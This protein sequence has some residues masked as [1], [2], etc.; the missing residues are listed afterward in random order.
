MLVPTLQMEELRRRIAVT[1]QVMRIKSR[2][3]EGM[4]SFLTSK[5]ELFPA[6][7]MPSPAGAGV[8]QPEPC[9]RNETPGAWRGECGGG[10]S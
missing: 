5:S 10:R 7:H 4:N 6:C 9:H 2:G 3:F 1:C 8:T